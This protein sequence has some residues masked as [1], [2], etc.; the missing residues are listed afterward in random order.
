MIA[1]QCCYDPCMKTNAHFLLAKTLVKLLDSQFSFLGIK[2]GLDP[3]MSILPGVGG[4]VPACLS[5]Y[6]VWIGYQHKIPDTDISRMIWNIVVDFVIG[7]VPFVGAVADIFIRSN[8][9]NLKILEKHLSTEEVQ[10][11]QTKD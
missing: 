3:L 9:K 11:L 7:S 6:I 5:F 10:F 8:E 2:F 4:I 1:Q